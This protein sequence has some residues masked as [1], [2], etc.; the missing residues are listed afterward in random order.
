M[1]FVLIV[2]GRFILFAYLYILYTFDLP[3]RFIIS[4]LSIWVNLFSFQN[5]LI[6]PSSLFTYQYIYITPPTFISTFWVISHM[7]I[8]MYTSNF[9]FFL[10]GLSNSLSSSFPLLS[11]DARG[12][13][14]CWGC[15]CW[16]S[17]SFPPP[18]FSSP[19]V[20]WWRSEFYTFP[21]KL[22]WLWAGYMDIK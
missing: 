9:F 18:I 13:L 19:L 17:L 10:P 6:S 22:W 4:W 5:F 21:G 20:L 8:Y 12:K 1:C 3:F 14:F 11:R 7:L 16:S 2:L 15:R